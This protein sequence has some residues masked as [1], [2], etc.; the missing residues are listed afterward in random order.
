MTTV[1]TGG[2]SKA[3]PLGGGLKEA[4]SIFGGVRGSEFPQPSRWWWVE[5]IISGLKGALRSHVK[6]SYIVVEPL[7]GCKQQNKR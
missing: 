1:F 2:V 4:C 5:V 6:R 7:L 3:L